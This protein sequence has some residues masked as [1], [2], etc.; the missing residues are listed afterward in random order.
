MRFATFHDHGMAPPSK[1]SNLYAHS[2]APQLRETGQST[3]EIT[4]SLAGRSEPF[5]S[6]SRQPWTI[7]VSSWSC[8]LTPPLSLKPPS[9]YKHDHTPRPTNLGLPSFVRFFNN[10]TLEPRRILLYLYW[11]HG[12]WLIYQTERRLFGCWLRGGMITPHDSGNFFTKFHLPFLTSFSTLL[13]DL[14]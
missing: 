4:C 3:L 7:K 12:I 14:C 13:V 1:V 2:Q 6:P 8:A 9:W 11:Y 5:A 10:K